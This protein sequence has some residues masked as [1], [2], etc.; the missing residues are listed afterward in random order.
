MKNSQW[1]LILCTFFCS[2]LTLAGVISLDNQDYFS[3]IAQHSVESVILVSTQAAVVLKYMANRRQAKAEEAEKR[4]LEAAKLEA[5]HKAAEA[6]K[7][8]QHELEL[9]KM[10]EEESSKIRAELREQ[11]E[12]TER[13]KI[14]AEIKAKIDKETVD[15]LAAQDKKTPVK[16]PRKKKT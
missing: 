8:R 14:E 16:R 7:I 12:K 5:E 10:K 15:K 9:L 1:W 2:G 4:R 11:I 6:E 13:A 3:S